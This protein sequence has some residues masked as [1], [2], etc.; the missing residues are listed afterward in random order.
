MPSKKYIARWLPVFLLLALSSYGQGLF[1][2]NYNVK[3]GLANATVYAAV[4]D[5][6]GFIWF[7]T[8]TGVSKFDG[9]RFRNYTKKTG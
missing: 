5:R 9:K 3:D 8:P 2:R 6:D 7:A 4:Q 1:I